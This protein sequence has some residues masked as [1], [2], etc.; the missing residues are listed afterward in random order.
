[1]EESARPSRDYRDLTPR[2]FEELTPEK[3]IEERVSGYRRWYDGKAVV[4]KRKY[5][6]MRSV[7]VVSGVLLPVLINFKSPSVPY[8]DYVVTAVSLVIA[9]SVSLEGVFHFR[10]QWKNYRSTEQYLGSEYFLFVSGEGVYRQ[11]KD[12][13]AYVT[14]V[15][16]IESAIASENASTLNILTT[17]SE[18]QKSAKGSTGDA[19]KS[20]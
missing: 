12:R 14:F 8:A 19:S 9:L 11:M 10:E 3:Y 7:T 15:E 4:A 18:D 5:F 1:M 17:V 2:G 13:D 6:W 16:R 20:A